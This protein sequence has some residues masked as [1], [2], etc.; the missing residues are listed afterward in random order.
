[1]VDA[2]F[3]LLPLS[4]AGAGATTIFLNELNASGFESTPD[5]VE[6]RTTR[7][8]QSCLELMDCDDPNAR[9]SRQF[10]LTPSE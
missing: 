9:L 7:L 8:A 1:M 4:Q 5:Y 2:S 6:G 3:I 10:L